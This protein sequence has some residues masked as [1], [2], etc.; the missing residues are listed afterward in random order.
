MV[1][2]LAFADIRDAV[3]VLST[4]KNKI[5]TQSKNL[6]EQKTHIPSCLC[7]MAFKASWVSAVHQSDLCEWIWSGSEKGLQTLFGKLL[8]SRILH[9][10]VEG[11]K[12]CWRRRISLVFVSVMF[13]G[14]CAFWIYCFMLKRFKGALLAFTCKRVITDYLN[15]S[16]K[17]NKTIQSTNLMSKIRHIVWY[18]W[19][20]KRYIKSTFTRHDRGKCKSS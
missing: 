11:V 10:K 18:L 4:V 5:N 20:K 16:Y 13:L 3:R 6:C 17:S 2:S 15:D 19:D 12:N 7:E 1:K 8:P 9:L 14:V